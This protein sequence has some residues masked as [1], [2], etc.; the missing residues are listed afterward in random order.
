MKVATA[1]RG[2]IENVPEW[3]EQVVVAILLPRLGWHVEKLGA[4]E[5]ADDASIAA[6]HIHDRHVPFLAVLE[7]LLLARRE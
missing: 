3:I 6:E 2:E 4:P 7:L 5:V 1:L